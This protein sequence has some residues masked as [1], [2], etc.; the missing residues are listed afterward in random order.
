MIL[1]VCGRYKM[2]NF[3]SFSPTTSFVGI[4]SAMMEMAMGC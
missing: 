1:N 3:M 2:K 4:L